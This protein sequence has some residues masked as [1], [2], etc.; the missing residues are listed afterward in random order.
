MP[1]RS[2]L[3]P[4]RLANRSHPWCVNVPAQLSPTGKRQQRFFATQ[5]EAQ[6]LCDQLKTRRDNFGV[7]LTAL[8]PARIAEAAECFD[9][10]DARGSELGLLGIVKRHLAALDQRKASVTLGALFDEYS[11]AKAHRT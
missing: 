4:T 9:L 6:T 3:K 11:A 7:T 8:S 1:R 2:I 5:R 10:L